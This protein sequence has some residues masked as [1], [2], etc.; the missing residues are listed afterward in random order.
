MGRHLIRKRTMTTTITT[1][2][3]RHLS[4]LHQAVARALISKGAWRL[5]DDSPAEH[6]NNQREDRP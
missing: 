5:V 3:L 2:Q 6:P 1:D 4:G